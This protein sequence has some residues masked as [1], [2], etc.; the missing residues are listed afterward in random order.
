[1]NS[2]SARPDAESSGWAWLRWG[3]W[4]L[5]VITALRNAWLCDDAYI[6]L[7]SVEQLWAGHGP[8]WNTGWRVQTF[9]GPLWYGI[10]AALRVGL[11]DGYLLALLPGLFFTALTWQR[12]R[13]RL[14]TPQ[15]HALLLAAWLVSNGFMDYTTSGLETALA[16]W[17]LSGF[18]H[19]YLPAAGDDLRAWPRLNAWA[20][21]VALTRLDLLALIAPAWLQRAWQARALPRRDWGRGLLPGLIPAGL[22]YGFALAYYGSPVP[23]PV[24]AKMFHGLP[25]ATVLAQGLRY[26]VGQ[27]LLDPVTLALILLFAARLLHRGGVQGRMLVAGAALYALDLTWVGGDFMAGRFPAFLYVWLLGGGL[28]LAPPPTWRGWRPKAALAA[29]GLYALLFPHTPVT[30]PWDHYVEPDFYLQWGVGDERGRYFRYTSL[31]TYVAWRLEPDAPPFFPPYAWSQM[32]Y[33]FRSSAEPIA[34]VD[35]VGMFGYWAGTEKMVLD[36]WALTDPFLARLPDADG[37]LWRPGHYERALPPGY[38]RSLRTGENHLRDPALRQLYD[39]TLWA[40]R[41]PVAAPERWRHLPRWWFVHLPSAPRP[42][43]AD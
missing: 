42:P 19:A 11:R 43:D 16:Y 3:L 36:V 37:R 5:F 30:S 8:V 2:K 20:G 40:T 25:R 34:V 6:Y 17:T 38:L 26:W 14:P 9:T 32:G 7:R 10:L 35:S 33:T 18:L 22:W 4:A 39:L 1:M 27:M 21:L 12:W 24:Y 28:I 15:A 23:N 29:L 13:Q 31:L 41:A